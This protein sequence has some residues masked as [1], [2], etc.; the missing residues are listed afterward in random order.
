LKKPLPNEARYFHSSVPGQFEGLLSARLKDSGFAPITFK[1][2]MSIG[3][4]KKP[5]SCS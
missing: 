3:N 4:S 1:E 2:E 5:I